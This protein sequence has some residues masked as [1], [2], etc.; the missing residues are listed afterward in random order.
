MKVDIPS[1]SSLPPPQRLAVAAILSVIGAVAYVASMQTAGEARARLR[2]EVATLKIQSA[3]LDRQA[4]E[5]ERLR[6][7]K[8]VVPGI[9]DLRAFLVARAEA[10][11][12]STARIRLEPEGAGRMR[13]TA[14][15][16]S[17]AGWL[18]WLGDLKAH[19]V[20]VE[21]CRVEALSNPGQVAITAVLVRPE[22]R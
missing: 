17:F 11:S 8:S 9:D 16:V 14:D 7:A 5:Y 1:Y 12:I 6:A 10:S 15:D 2:A 3:R 21:S 13:V 19:Q 22:S 20:N 18:A 4:A